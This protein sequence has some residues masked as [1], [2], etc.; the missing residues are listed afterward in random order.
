MLNKR[1]INTKPQIYLPETGEFVKVTYETYRGYYK[2]IEKER[3][4]KQKSGEC[5]CG[6]YH[7][8]K[9]NGD[10]LVC[11]YHRAGKNISLELYGDMSIS[12]VGNPEVEY[13][14]KEQNRALHDAI[15]KLEP[16]EKDA[17]LVKHFSDSKPLS[18]HKS[19]EKLELSYS[20][21]RNYYLKGKE[22]LAILMQDWR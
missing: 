22:R 10:C 21:F 20:A 1:K 2:D 16:E 14:K 8:S 17:I 3:K 9:C 4:R 11:K 6:V 7:I 19:A 18:L 5:V 12:S 15:L 13:E